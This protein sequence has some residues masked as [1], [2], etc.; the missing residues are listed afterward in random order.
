MKKLAQHWQILIGMAVGIIAGV[1]ALQFE[2]GTQ[3]VLNWLKP[4]GTIFINMLK[5]IAIPLIIASL[6]KG[7]AEL[8]DVT[9][10][11]NLGVRTFIINTI[12]TVTSVSL[13]LLLVNTI[14]PGKFVSER[15]RAEMISTFGADV[16]KKVATIT[17]APKTGPLQPIVDIV[18]DNFFSAASANNNMLQVI[19]FVILFGV[20]LILIPPDKA[21]P[22]KAFFDGSNEVILKI[23]DI[24][25][26]FAPYAVVGLLAALV[27]ESPAP[28]IFVALGAYALTI[29]L[30]I[31]ILLFIFYPFAVKFFTGRS[32]SFFMRGIAPAQLVAFSTSSSAATLPVTLERV[33]EH[34]GVDK[35]VSSFVLPIGATVNMDGT[36][37]YQAV[38]TVFIAQVLGT[39]LTF[40]DQ[41]MIVLTAS[42]AAVGTAAVPGA[43]LLMLVVVLESVGVNPAGIALIIA[44]DRPLDMCRTI[45]NVTSDACVAM[46]VAKQTGKLHEPKPVEW[47]SSYKK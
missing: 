40:A 45:A 47:N 14:N 1:V 4:W 39:D 35:E 19:F 2:G 37:L 38:A 20:G 23:I 22:V 15:T 13:G 16:E 28:D 3:F 24:I 9:A 43:G 6:I 10:L 30:G 29:L 11:S 33:E 34:L 12:T 36:S 42:L 7:V 25:M 32:Y 46:I 18:P 27:V 26:M 21:A 31:A 17:E 44:I 41:L 5:L 8:K